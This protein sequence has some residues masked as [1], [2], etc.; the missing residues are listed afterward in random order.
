MPESINEITVTFGESTDDDSWVTVMESF[1]GFLVRVNE[2]I[3]IEVE[4]VR[5]P[6]T[7]EAGFYGLNDEF[8]SWADVWSVHYY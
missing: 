7:G 2:E 8:V 4:A 6:D 1:V 5:H 3:D